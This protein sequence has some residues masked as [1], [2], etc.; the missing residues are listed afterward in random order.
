MSDYLVEIVSRGSVK[1]DYEDKKAE[2]TSIKVPEY[3]SVD[4]ISQKVTVLS[5]EKDKYIEKVYT[6]IDGISSLIF[7]A[8]KITPKQIFTV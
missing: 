5:I 1:I 4:G 6:G 7:P 3:W 2:Y 8:L